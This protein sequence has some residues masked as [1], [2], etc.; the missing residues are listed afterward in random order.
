[1]RPEKI[2]TDL[3]V[4]KFSKWGVTLTEAQKSDIKAQLQKDHIEEFSIIVTDAQAEQI[5]NAGYDPQKLNL[6][7]TD[8]DKDKFDQKFT[9]V[10]TETITKLARTFGK[11]IF[12]NWKNQANLTLK[13]ERKISIEVNRQIKKQWAKPLKNLEM[14]LSISRQL[15]SEFNIYLISNKA[16]EN[17]LV[18]EVLTRSHGRACQ[19]GY[20]IL[21]LL[22]N[23]FADGGY[24]RWR[25]LHEITVISAF[26][27]QHNNELA[28]R[29]LDHTVITNFHE[30]EAYQK[31]CK[32]LSLIPISDEEIEFL[33]AN[34]EKA[35]KRYGLEFDKDYGW[36]SIVLD[37]P[38][39]FAHIE[40]EVNL[41]H[42]RLF[43]KTANVNIHAGSKGILF[44]LGSQN[45][46][47][48]ILAGPSIFGLYEVGRRTAY[49]IALITSIVLLSKPNLDRLGYVSA[50][51]K[52]RDEACWAFDKAEASFENKGNNS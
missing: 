49:S 50:I 23:G 10:I 6:D 44:R 1:M 51:E 15:G 25:T 36:A 46:S 11:E 42:L 26:I 29:Y 24:A 43:Y 12:K 30:A 52:L 31:N 27:A 33:K 17:D 19:V 45:N 32:S 41:D 16:K 9:N 20:E 37:K 18:L 48:M 8:F 28:Q 39:T 40:E 13:N 21:T 47:N 2:L 38:L 34:R 3:F 7:F 14:L 35:L 4:K 22:S 5:K